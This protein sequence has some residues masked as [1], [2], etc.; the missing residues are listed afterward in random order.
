MFDGDEMNIFVPQS[1]QAQI[2]L[3]DIADVKR[4][5]VTPGSSAPIIGVIQDNLVG[6]Y[7]LTQPTMRIDW[8]DAMNIVSYTSIDD[9]SYFKKN[10]DYKGTDIFSLIIPS[11]ITTIK[12]GLEVKQG[13]IIKGVTKKSHLGSGKKGSLIHLILD[14]YGM[15]EAKMF[16][17]NTQRLVV[18][19]NFLNGATV[20][21]GDIDVSQKLKEEINT[22]IETSKL[23]ISHLITEMENNPDMLE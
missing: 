12:D 20:G 13:K 17:D 22:S 16:L 1:V 2:E 18:N 6:S 5:F 7:N 8:K 14:E 19:F 10:Q 23:E 11:G 3:S 15:D 4:E 9:F 21:I